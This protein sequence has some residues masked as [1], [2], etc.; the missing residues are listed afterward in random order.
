MLDP[1][2]QRAVNFACKDL[3]GKSIAINQ[4]D[5][6]I[7]SKKRYVHIHNLMQVFE[8]CRKYGISLN[9]K[10]F[11]L[12]VD[13]GKN[14]G[15][16]TSK[17]GVKIDPSRVEAIQNIPLPQCK[18]DIQYFFGKINFIAGFIPNFV[19]ITKPIS[20]LLK[21]DSIFKWNDESRVAFNKIKQAISSAPVLVSPARFSNIFI[22][23]R[24][25]YL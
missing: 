18:K 19:E 4:D 24:G 10:K 9:P 2:S 16:I 11:V 23:I 20:N 21:K 8:I 22:C 25:H 3:I 12:G 17:D 15:H 5:L 1:L 6:V 7:F 14:L 13:E